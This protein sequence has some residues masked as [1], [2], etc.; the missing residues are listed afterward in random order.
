MQTKGS[1]FN[2]VTNKPA[3][4]VAT[5]GTMVDMR[6]MAD[7]IDAE[8]TLSTLEHKGA[9]KQQG[10]TSQYY[11]AVLPSEE[12]E[13]GG[14]QDRKNQ[15]TNEHLHATIDP[16]KQ[17]KGVGEAKAQHKLSVWANDKGAPKQQ[18]R[19]SHYYQA[20]L[21]SE[22]S[23]ER[24]QEGRQAISLLIALDGVNKWASQDLRGTT[25][26][27]NQA[28]SSGGGKTPRNLGAWANREQVPKQQ[29][30]TSQY[31]LAE[32]QSKEPEG[33]KWEESRAFS[34]FHIAHGKE[35]QLASQDPRAATDHMQQA[36]G[37]GKQKTPCKLSEW[38]NT[39]VH[40]SLQVG[41]SSLNLTR[42]LTEKADSEG[43]LIQDAMPSLDNKHNHQGL[44]VCKSD[45]QVLQD[46]NRQDHVRNF[47]SS[48]GEIPVSYASL[49]SVRFVV[50][51]EKL[52]PSGDIVV[53]SNNSLEV[54][55]E[56]TLK[57]PA[58]SFKSGLSL[59][60][61]WIHILVAL[62]VASTDGRISIFADAA[63][64]PRNRNE[65]Q[66]DGGG[67]LGVFGCVGSCGSS[68]LPTSSGYTYCNNGAWTSGTGNS[69]NNAATGVPNGQGTG[70]YGTMGSW[71]VSKVD[72]MGWS[73][74]IT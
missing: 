70:T 25:D 68:P 72:N 5:A 11:L 14:A 58:G 38:T 50:K 9:P 12:P 57:S 28:M 45:L 26:A 73:K 22:E 37:T 21:P 74:F 56:S 16:T 18:Q 27:E 29:G 69:C 47:S 10:R 65:L 48:L 6:N 64:A 66:G 52:P 2:S 63:F 51:Q 17:A 59:C 32:L 49:I 24:E 42:C 55:M 8:D 60:T 43:P 44:G 46:R 35:N 15:R 19:S 3:P 34:S 36:K 61:W 1:N 13:G 54:G 41:D 31:Y 23:A 40:H 20:Q 33:G 7:A 30:R 4:L 62:A 53:T 71:D 67:S 39:S